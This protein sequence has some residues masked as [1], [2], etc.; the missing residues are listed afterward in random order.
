[1]NFKMK[2]SK[3]KKYSLLKRNNWSV[4]FLLIITFF[5]IN[6]CEKAIDWELKSSQEQFLI[7]DGIITNEFKNQTIKLSLSCSDINGSETAVTDATVY[8]SDG[9]EIYKFL[10]DTENNGIYTSE[11]KFSGVVNRTYS[12]YINYKNKEYT[13]KA[14]MLPVAISEPLPYKQVDGTNMFYIVADIATFNPNNASMYEVILDWSDVA[15]YENLPISETSA[16][17]FFYHL[18]TIDVNQIF[19]ENEEITYFPTRTRM[20][21]K[22]Y[23]LSKEHEKFIR[24][25]LIET[26]WHGSYFDIEEGNVYTNINGNALGFFGACS[27]IS[28]T[29]Y[30]N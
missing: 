5:M 16:D 1:M 29:I 22:K 7:V 3:I 26:Q 27:V 12:L 13:A 30:V 11:N 14:N 4:F 10:V 2:I 25:L 21:Q 15:G 20:T 24:S 19:S 9:N 6:S 23:S 17:M 28:K 8:V 18:T